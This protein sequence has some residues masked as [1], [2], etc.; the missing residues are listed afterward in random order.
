MNSIKSPRDYQK[1]AIKDVVLGLEQ[2]GKGQLILP[3]GAGK[4][5]TSYWIT[6]KL[7]AK[8][9]LVLVPSLALLKQIK[10]AWSEMDSN[11]SVYVF[12]AKKILIRTHIVL[13]SLRSLMGPR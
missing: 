8:K 3:C 4:T 9:V 2:Y 11:E 7:K 12:A 13:N 6:K 5:L 10:D 1:E